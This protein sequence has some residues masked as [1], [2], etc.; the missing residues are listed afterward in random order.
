MVKVNGHKLRRFVFWFIFIGGI[1]L[2]T[3]LMLYYSGYRFSF[4]QGRV[5][6]VG[7]LSVNV[8]PD[9]SQVFLNGEKLGYG[10]PGLFNSIAPGE[11]TVRV[12]HAG[13]SS[14]EFPVT[15]QS[16]HTTIVDGVFLPLISNPTPAAP[17]PHESIL[18]TDQLELVQQL[19]NWPIWK[20][21]GTDPIAFISGPERRLSV[22]LDHSLLDIDTSVTQVAVQTPLQQLA[23][24]IDGTAW[25]AY[26][27][28]NRFEP[29]ILTRQTESFVDVALIPDSQA[30]ILADPHSLQLV[31]VGPEHAVSLTPLAKGT[32]IQRVWVNSTGK[33]VMF[34]DGDQ[35]FEF[36]IQN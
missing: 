4:D 2:I 24:T 8:R 17:P 6:R 16:Q 13:F 5:I 31:Q 14:L 34:Q 3:L 18:T 22:F 30:V 23:Y 26:T 28:E 25:L 15:L 19:H 10:T 27:N 33:I 11:Y 7:S 9:N 1:S 20:I 29:F 21:A 35:W 12:E 32:W 36:P